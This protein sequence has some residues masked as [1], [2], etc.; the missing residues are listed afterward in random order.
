MVQVRRHESTSYPAHRGHSG[1]SLIELAVTLVIVSTIAVLSMPNFI[2]WISN[3]R[4]RASAEAIVSGIRQAQVEAI[5]RNVRVEL[6]LTND[7]PIT[8]TVTPTTSG[9]NWVVRT[10]APTSS[11]ITGKSAAEGGTGVTV[12]ASQAA[13]P[14]NGLGRIATGAA[15][16]S[17]NVTPP[18]GGTRPLRIV[19]AL[20][21]GVRICD[22]ALSLTDVR[23]C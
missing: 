7:A 18:S 4:T 17:I 19:V 1:F 15:N 20:G 11:F 3:S 2:E 8:D 14:F 9:Q 21:G 13:I 23:A 5:S 12:L 22:P 10:P 6:V 16:I